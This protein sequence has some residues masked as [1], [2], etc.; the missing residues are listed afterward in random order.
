MPGAPDPALV[1]ARRALPDGLSALEPHL[2]CIVVVGALALYLHTGPS[3]LA[4]AE[5]TTD[6]DLVVEPQFLASEPA[7]GRL[8]ED[9]GFE[10]LGDPGRWRSPSHT[11][12]DLMVPEALAGPGRRGARLPGHGK[13]AARRCRGLEGAL[14]D[15]ERR[16]IRSLD[17]SDSRAVQVAVAGPTA[18][19]V[20]KVH[21]IAERTSTPDRLADKDPLD[22][23]RLLRSIPLRTLV[24]GLTRLR[25]DDLAR[26]VTLEASSLARDLFGTTSAP[27]CEMAARAVAGLDDPDVVAASLVVL[28]TDLLDALEAAGD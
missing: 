8:L 24:E 9:R 21:K 6:A 10:H 25:S 26:D 16:I 28:V 23:L 11:Q 18:L 27:G 12:V 2:D 4:V 3:Q 22:L 1:E 7:I 15:R 17:D 19:F 13:H 5:F 20:A 14:V